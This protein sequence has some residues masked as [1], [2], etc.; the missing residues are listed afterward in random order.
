METTKSVCINEY[1]ILS[2]ACRYHRPVFQAIEMSK[3]AICGIAGVTGVPRPF[4]W[5]SSQTLKSKY[6]PLTEAVAD[7]FMASSLTFPTPKLGGTLKYFCELA[8]QTSMTR[9]HHRI[10][11]RPRTKE[12]ELQGLVGLLSDCN[13]PYVLGIRCSR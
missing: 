3:P 2:L 13:S 7:S 11:T 1:G 9:S 10:C 8:K 12:R 6:H 5:S 4:F